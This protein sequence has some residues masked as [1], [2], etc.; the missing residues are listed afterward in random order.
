MIFVIDRSFITL[1]E[2]NINNIDFLIIMVTL[3]TKVIE[4]DMGHRVPNHK[5]K[6][7]NLHGHRYRFEVAV[8]GELAA[9]QGS[10]D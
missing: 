10:S 4:I 9:E 3:V 6:C 1:S 2:N 7:K 5:S 8:N